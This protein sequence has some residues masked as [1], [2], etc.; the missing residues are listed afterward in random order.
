MKIASQSRWW[1]KQCDEFYGSLF[2]AL[3]FHFLFIRIKSSWALALVGQVCVQSLDCFFWNLVF[4]TDHFGLCDTIKGKLISN[5][6]IHNTTLC[7]GIRLTR[8]ESC[9][10]NS[11]TVSSSLVFVGVGLYHDITVVVGLPSNVAMII[12]GWIFSMLLRHFNAL[13]LRSIPTPPIAA[14]V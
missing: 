9:L 3:F 12:L 2:R 8:E 4:N 14:F 5:L 6:G 10:Q 7:F 11:S 1:L 13:G